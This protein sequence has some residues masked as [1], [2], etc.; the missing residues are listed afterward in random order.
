ME[1][2]C[3]LKQLDEQLKTTREVI[4]FIKNTHQQYEKIINL[5]EKTGFT[6]SFILLARV[7]CLLYSIQN[8]LENRRF[9]S[10]RLNIRH[11]HEANHLAVYFKIGELKRNEKI[12]SDVS[13][14]FRNKII[15]NATVRKFLAKEWAAKEELLTDLYGL[16]SKH[17]HNCIRPIMQSYKQ[18]YL[19]NGEVAISVKGGFDYEQE[20]D[21]Q[22][23]IELLEL[24]KNSIIST[25]TVLDTC[26]M[27][28]LSQ[29]EVKTLKGYRL[30][31]DNL[32]KLVKKPGKK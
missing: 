15:I 28:L 11:I 32:E 5:E 13:K 8:D 21:N 16:Y 12:K 26:L 31:I 4:D 18:A 20:R 27:A 29:E 10:G 1:K 23:L 24:F 6:A 30:I 7:I 9:V 2:T 17:N 3:P 22:N 14:W 19:K 25:L